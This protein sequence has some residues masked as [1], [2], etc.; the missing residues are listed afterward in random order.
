MALNYM[1]LNYFGGHRSRA[2]DYLLRRE[3]RDCA[4]QHHRHVPLWPLPHGTRFDSC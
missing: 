2:D 3:A 1:A 4:L